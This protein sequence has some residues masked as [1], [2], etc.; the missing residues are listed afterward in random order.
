M[1]SVGFKSSEVTRENG[2][3]VVRLFVSE[4]R[5][6]CVVLLRCADAAAR[7]LARGLAKADAP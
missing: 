3:V 6:T 5:A 2:K 1:L 7:E 4:K